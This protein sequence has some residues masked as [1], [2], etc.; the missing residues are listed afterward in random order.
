MKK[1]LVTLALLSVVLCGMAQSP[2]AVSKARIVAD[3][4]LN[5]RH[6]T[7]APHQLVPVATG[8]ASCVAF[9]K[10]DGKGF[11]IVSADEGDSNLV[12]GYADNGSF[13]A[14]EMPDGLREWLDLMSA[15]ADIVR[16][17][18]SARRILAT[19]RGNIVVDAL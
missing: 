6:Q 15:E 19:T 3:E 9:N 10:S 16:Q 5:A 18:G 2:A 17:G 8:T 13:D 14:S 4:F 11:V 1:L 7:V 12:L